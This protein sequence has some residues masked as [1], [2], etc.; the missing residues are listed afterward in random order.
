MLSPNVLRLVVVCIV[1]HVV[2]R[3]ENVPKSELADAALAPGE[4]LLKGEVDHEHYLEKIAKL[5]KQLSVSGN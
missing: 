3:T 5:E 4:F 1:C 2:V